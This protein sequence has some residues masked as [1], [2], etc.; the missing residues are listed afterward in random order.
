MALEDWTLAILC[1]L[2]LWN[3]AYK[4]AHKWAGNNNWRHEHI[5][6][7]NPDMDK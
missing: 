6:Q 7:I 3:Q 1:G 2:E 5:K 4:L